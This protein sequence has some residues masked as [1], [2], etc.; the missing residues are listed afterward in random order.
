MDLFKK[1][2][3]LDYYYVLPF[4]SSSVTWLAGDVKEP[5]HLSE[6]V[7][8]DVPGFV[9]WPLPMEKSHVF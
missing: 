2:V 1:E 7:G 9:V 6:R 3:K 4:K 8:D 5:T